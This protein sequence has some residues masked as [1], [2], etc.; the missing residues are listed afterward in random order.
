MWLLVLFVWRGRLDRVVFIPSGARDLAV[1]VAFD[2]HGNLKLETALLAKLGY[3][4]LR[5]AIN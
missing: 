1:A 5:Q 4:P 3:P 2:F